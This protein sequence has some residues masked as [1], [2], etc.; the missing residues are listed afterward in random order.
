MP[1]RPKERFG[2]KGDREARLGSASGLNKQSGLNCTEHA[3]SSHGS[4][5]RRVYGETTKH[6][7][8]ASVLTSNPLDRQVG[9]RGYRCPNRLGFS[10]WAGEHV[11]DVP[12][13]G[14]ALLSRRSAQ[15][16][17]EHAT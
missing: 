16:E 3:P 4:G 7:M 8:E 9:P 13:G 15:P 11:S 6:A 2:P 12:D 14:S 5:Y 1:P 10:I 17:V